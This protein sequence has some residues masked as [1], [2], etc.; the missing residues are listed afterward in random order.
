MQH[1]HKHHAHQVLVR[2]TVSASKLAHLP[3]TAGVQPTIMEPTAST[4]TVSS[5]LWGR[6]PTIPAWTVLC[7]FSWPRPWTLASTH[8]YV[9]RAMLEP[10]VRLISD[11]RL[12]VR[13]TT[14]TVLRVAHAQLTP[15]PIRSNVSAR[16]FTPELI[17][18]SFSMPVSQMGK[19]SKISALRPKKYES[20][21]I[22]SSSQ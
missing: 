20:E 16:L 22:S 6:V 3:S 12:H 9:C 7:A 17:V 8:A 2:I 19:F 14:A 13:I 21:L 10:I 5:V 18:T 11:L 4:L 15:T 1:G